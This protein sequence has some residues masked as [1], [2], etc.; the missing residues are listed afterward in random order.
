MLTNQAPLSQHGEYLEQF[1]S[2]QDHNHSQ[3]NQSVALEKS[4]RNVMHQ[5]LDNQGQSITS[6][7]LNA[8]LP[9]SQ[10]H[11]LS[12]QQPKLSA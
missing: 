10:G 2:K 12:V 8:T 11:S 9:G 3:Y 4:N 1:T 6:Q 5:R 7:N